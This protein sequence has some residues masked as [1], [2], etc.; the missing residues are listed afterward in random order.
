M[1][2]ADQITEKQMTFK[3]EITGKN[4]RRKKGEKT[5]AFASRIETAREA[6]RARVSKQRAKWAGRKGKYN[7]KGEHIDGHWFASGAEARRYEQLKEL[8]A[9]GL[10]DSLELQPTFRVDI[11][12]QLI[13]NYRADFGYV[14]V[15]KM[16][17][18]VRSV[19]ED[20]K[21]FITPEYKLKRKMV[22]AKFGIEIA[23]IPS[24]DVVKKWQGCVPAKKAF[25][26]SFK[27]EEI[28]NEETGLAD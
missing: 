5:A 13:C 21:G 11:N 3:C 19:T 14:I 20:V 12:N 15:D 1:P 16:G 6:Q 10:I 18:P 22:Q 24:R 2:V 8:E 4:Y 26:K 17:S 7:A 23:E 25:E 9:L 28:A 27:P